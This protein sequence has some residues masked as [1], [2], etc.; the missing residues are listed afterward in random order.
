MASAMVTLQHFVDIL[1]L[2]MRKLDIKVSDWAWSPERTVGR[3]IWNA[4]LSTPPAMSRGCLGPFCR[5]TGALG[6][7]WQGRGRHVAPLTT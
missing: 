1:I 4:G 5:G 2:Q 7:F 3:V 6:S